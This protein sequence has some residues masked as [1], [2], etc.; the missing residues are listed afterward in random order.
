MN[1]DLGS[2][3]R[4]HRIKEK[5]TVKQVS[6]FLTNKGFRASE[7]TIYSWEKGGSQPSP[8]VFLLLC[9]MYNIS[10]ILETFGY[11]KEKK[12]SFALSIDDIEHIKKYH[13][14]DDCSKMVVDTIID[15]ELK[16]IEENVLKNSEAV[17][18]NIVYINFAQNSAS[19]GSGD[20]LFGDIDDAPLALVENRITNK[21]DFA[22]RVNGNSM[23]PNF[24]NGDIVLASKQ[25]VD[26]GDIGLFVVNGNGYIKKKGSRELIS[27]NPK[28]DNVQISEYD[29]VYCM[30]KVIGKVEDEWMR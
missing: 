29:T 26:N 27:L 20:V 8:D 16:R 28:F 21:A 4:E 9:R 14:L 11:N 7:K 2:V 3:L 30:G 5:I 6:D 12:D 15:F 19:A 25:P 10:N 23:L 13:N 1:A 22:V 17:E 24:S 18:E